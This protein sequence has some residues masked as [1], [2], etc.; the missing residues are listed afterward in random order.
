MLMIPRAL[1]MFRSSTTVIVHRTV[2]SVGSKASPGHA[3]GIGDKAGSI[4][5]RTGLYRDGK[6]YVFDTDNT[7]FAVLT[8]QRV[9]AVLSDE[10]LNSPLL[11]GL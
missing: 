9:S 6:L 3:D 4:L 2:N 7:V 5:F 1:S 10:C 11:L 8:L